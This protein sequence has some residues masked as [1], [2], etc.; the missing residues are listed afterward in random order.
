M[1]NNWH[2]QKNRTVIALLLITETN[3]VIL[4]DKVELNRTEQKILQEFQYEKF[5]TERNIK[6]DV[7]EKE[8]N[9]G[10]CILFFNESQRV[11]AVL[12]K[13]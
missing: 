9:H 5:Y 6:F 12:I 7:G 8:Y 3:K 13:Y 10:H 2:Y 11:I 1:G 4:N